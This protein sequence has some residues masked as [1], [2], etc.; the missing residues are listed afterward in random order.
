MQPF[1][2]QNSQIAIEGMFSHWIKK[3]DNLL[4]WKTYIFAEVL[5]PSKAL[6][7]YCSNSLIH[8]HYVRNTEIMRYRRS[9]R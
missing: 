4:Q 2:L 8:R 9:T 3:A 1:T 6:L 5:N 7:V